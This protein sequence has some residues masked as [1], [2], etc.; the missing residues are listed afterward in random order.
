MGL[1]TT[2]RTLLY[3]D[4][5]TRPCDGQ[6]RVVVATLQSLLDDDPTNEAMQT[7]FNDLRRHGEGGQMDYREF[8]KQEFYWL[9]LPMKAALG[10][11][12]ICV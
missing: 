11:C 9:A 7:E 6:W 1:S 4:L 2:A 3:R 12:S 8:R 5:R 10:R